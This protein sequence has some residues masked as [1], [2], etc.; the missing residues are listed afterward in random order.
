MDSNHTDRDF[1][2]VLGIKHD[3]TQAEIKNAY[4][5]KAMLLHPDRNKS[6]AATQEFQEVLMAYNTLSNEIQ[7]KEYDEMNNGDRLRLY[8]MWRDH[9]SRMLPSGRRTY[10]ALVKL[11]YPGETQL[12]SDI[13]RLDFDSIFRTITHRVRSNYTQWIDQLIDINSEDSSIDSRDPKAKLTWSGGD[14]E[15]NNIWDNRYRIETRESGQWLVAN[16]YE[17]VIGGDRV[18]IRGTEMPAYKMFPNGDL[19][20]DI[21]I[22][23]HTF[24]Y[25]GTAHFLFLDQRMIPLEVSPINERYR[26]YVVLEQGGLTPNKTKQRGKLSIHFKVDRLSQLEPFIKKLLQKIQF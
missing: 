9:I 10:R 11:L 25:G 17:V 6:D 7:R 2:S 8:R 1:Y 18:I 21:R 19:E 16:D 23:L 14:G 3:A 4:R 20:T 13:N 24:L 22:D 5:H 12:K 26:Q 15:L